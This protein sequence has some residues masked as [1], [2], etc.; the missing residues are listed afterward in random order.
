MTNRYHL[1]VYGTLRKGWGNHRLIEDAEF[2][3]EAET[4]GNHALLNVGPFPALYL[5]EQFCPVRGEVYL[6]D[7]NQFKAVERL[8]GYPHHYNRDRILTTLGWAWAYFYDDHDGLP[9][10]ETGDWADVDSKES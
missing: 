10:I 2:L 1:F 4:A 3:G 5:M 6:V 7:R 9:I 8:E